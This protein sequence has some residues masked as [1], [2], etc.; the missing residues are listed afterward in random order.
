ME[1]NSKK[2]I[3]D[4]DEDMELDLRKLIN[5][6]FQ[7]KLWIICASIIGMVLGIGFAKLKKKPTYQA[8]LTMYVV[9]ENDNNKIVPESSADITLKVNTAAELLKSGEVL[10][11][12]INQTNLNV[13]TDQLIRSSKIKTT[14]KVQ[15]QVIDVEVSFDNEKDTLS[16]AQKLAEIA[17]KKISSLMHEE[18]S[19]EVVTTPSQV[20]VTPVSLRSYGLKG[21]MA[22]FGLSFLIVVALAL[23]DHQYPKK[24]SD[25]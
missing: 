9:V 5:T 11:E 3:L 25:E 14:V 8:K 1:Q 23:F 24:K 7:K 19:I 20:Q 15:T 12:V 17:P 13:E 21:F 18:A 2:K 22:G 16:I 10:G 6:I 4:F